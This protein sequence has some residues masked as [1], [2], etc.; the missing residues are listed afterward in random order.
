LYCTV[1]YQIRLY[2]FVINWKLMISRVLYLL[3]KIIKLLYY[4]IMYYIVLY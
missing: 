1:L 2:Y 3:C 4:T